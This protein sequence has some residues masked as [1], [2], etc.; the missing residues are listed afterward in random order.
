M[1]ALAIPLGAMLA[2]SVNLADIILWGVVALV[3]QL[4]A[5]AAVAMLVRDLPQAIERGEICAGA[6]AGDGADRRRHLQRGGDVRLSAMNAARARGDFLSAGGRLPQII[7]HYPNFSDSFDD[8]DGRRPLPAP[9]DAAPPSTGDGPPPD[10][11]RRPLPEAAPDDP[12][13]SVEA[14]SLQPDEIA[15]GTSFPDR[16]RHLAHRAPCREWRSATASF[17]S[18]TAAKWRRRSPICIRKPISRS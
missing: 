17:S 16:A 13:I 5:F 1:L 2:H 3:L 11:V 12:L 15:F 10:R 14:E 18:S 6:G 9:E 8:G 4:I 7:A